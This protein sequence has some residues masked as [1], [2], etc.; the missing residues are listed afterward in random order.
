MQ[1]CM[2]NGIAV[3]AYSPLCRA[4]KFSH[5][6]VMNIAKKHEKTPAQVLIRWSLQKGLIC[7]PKSVNKTRIWENIDVYDFDLDI[8]DIVD[9]DCLEEEFRTGRDK[10]KSAWTG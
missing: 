10:L 7:I 3:M 6:T 9:L 4:R 5:E 2:D 8:Q 1:Y